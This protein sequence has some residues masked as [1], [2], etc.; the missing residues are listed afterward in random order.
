LVGVVGILFATG[1]AQATTTAVFSGSLNNRAARAEFVYGDGSLQVTLTNTSP[2]D[3]LVPSEVLT[4]VFFDVDPLVTFTRVSAMLASGSEVFFGLTDPGGVVGGE[5]AFQSGLSGAPGNAV[6]GLSSSGFDLFGPHDLFPGTDLQ[7]PES[8]DGIQYGITSAGDDPATGNTPVTGENALI[9]NS[10]VF[11]LTYEEPANPLRI[12][13]VWFQ[14]GTGLTEPSIP[15]YDVGEP[16]PVI[17]EPF[18]LV[19][20][21]LAVSGLGVYHHRRMK[22][23][24]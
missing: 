23:T 6:L 10:V 15:S 21:L 20:C 5:F 24:D 9:K 14:Y 8:P 4:A 19:S 18:T 1:A 12:Y 2:D 22:G 16:P 7:E 11:Q 3:V 13:N 17:P